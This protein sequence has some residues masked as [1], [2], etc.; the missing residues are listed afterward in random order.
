[1]KD[2]VSESDSLSSTSG[3]P[4]ILEYRKISEAPRDLFGV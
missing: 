2:L 1:M 4:K 3:E